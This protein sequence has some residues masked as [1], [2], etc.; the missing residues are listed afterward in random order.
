ME[1]LEAYRLMWF[2]LIIIVVLGF[3]CIGLSI[4]FFYLGLETGRKAALGVPLNMFGGAQKGGAFQAPDPGQ[5]PALQNGGQENPLQALDAVIGRAL[6]DIG[7]GRST[8][9]QPG[10]TP[11][12]LVDPELAG[13]APTQARDGGES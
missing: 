2:G 1:I 3:G 12:N 6:G 13:Y 7:R 4:W 11:E 5:G 8:K 9:T 10:W